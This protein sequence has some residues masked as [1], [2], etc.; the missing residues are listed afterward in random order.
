MVACSSLAA[1]SSAADRAPVKINKP[2]MA[3]RGRPSMTSLL[4]EKGSEQPASRKHPPRRLATR[5]R[6]YY[7]AVAGDSHQPDVGF[8]GSAQSTLTRRNHLPVPAPRISPSSLFQPKS[9]RSQ[10]GSAGQIGLPV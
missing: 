1:S 7:D 4:F 8:F 6:R 3:K 9:R 5:R 10:H 2:A